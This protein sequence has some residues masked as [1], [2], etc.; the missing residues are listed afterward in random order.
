[1]LPIYRGRVRLLPNSIMGS[2]DVLPP[3]CRIAD[4]ITITCDMQLQEQLES[5]YLL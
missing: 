3:T 2:P 4:F 5:S 1:M